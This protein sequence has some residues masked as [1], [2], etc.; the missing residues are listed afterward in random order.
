MWSMEG[1]DTPLTSS[2]ALLWTIE[3][4]PVL[5]SA[6]V[7]IAVLDRRPDLTRLHE[8]FSD[9]VVVFP[10]LA[11]HI[12]A[13]RGGLP[14][15]V[16]MPDWHLDHHITHVQLPEPGSFRQLL[17]L[18]GEQVGEAF[19]P[20]RPLWHFTIVEGL[21]HGRT[22][23]VMK[24]H[25]SVTDGVGGI[26]LLSSFTDAE[27]D[28]Q[29][30]PVSPVAPHRRTKTSRPG[31]VDRAAAA[32]KSVVAHPVTT[33]TNAPKAARSAA[34]LVAPNPH[35][36]SPVTVGRGLDRRLDTLEVALSDL[37]RAGHAVDGTVNDAFLAAV[38]GG[39][40]RYHR[41]HGADPDE[42]RVTMPISVRRPDDAEGGNRF[43]PARFAVPMNIDDP[44]ARMRAVGELARG[45]QH[46]PAVGLTDVMADVLSHLPAGVTTSIFGSML[47][48]MDFVATNIPGPRETRWLAGAEVVGLHGFGPT[49]GSA[50]SFAMLSHVGTCSVGVNVDTTAIADPEVL[51]ECLTEGFDEV[52]DVDRWERSP[53]GAA[54]RGLVPEAAEIPARL[55]ALDDGFLEA[56][57]PRTPMHVGAL[58][59]LEGEA[60]LDGNGDL[61]LD[62]IRAEISR[63][64]PRAPRMYQR[65]A[66][67][68]IGRPF[69]EHDPH[70]DVAAHVRHERL[71]S[72]GTRA[73]LEQL[74]CELQMRVLDRSRPLWEMW[75]IDGLADGSVALVHKIHHA[76]VDGVSAAE[77]F[78]VLLGDDAPDG[79]ASSDVSAGREPGLAKPGPGG[80]RGMVAG[81]TD[82]ARGV[83]KWWIRSG[84]EAAR[85]PVAAVTRAAGIVD[86]LTQAPLAPRSSLNGP[87]GADRRLASQTFSVADL[88]SVGRRHGATVNDVVLTLVGAGLRTLLESRGERIDHV[89]VLVPVSLR[90]ADDHDTAGNKVAAVLLPL[91]LDEPDPV[92]ALRAVAD[93]TSARKSG[94]AVA[95][96]DTLLRWTDTWPTTLLGPVSRFTV[97]RQP[98]VNL[99]VTNVRG[100]D[101]PLFLLGAEITEIT[102]IVPLGGNLTLGVAVLSYNGRLVMGLHADADSCPDLDVMREGIERAYE[103]L[104]H[105]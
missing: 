36:L 78:E 19:D 69:W 37:Q 91:D 71:A 32:A 93:E 89:Q 11:Q 56:E 31:N 5:R 41:L 79:A 65:L 66:E 101:H 3:R 43:T 16:D 82:D 9:A 17:D 72:P 86:L 45:W 74:C 26:G 75:F 58:V 14:R 15:W 87:V 77:T 70:F 80:L 85:D 21:D 30:D 81:L 68:P 44:A 33:I 51:L 90:G 53:P 103:A 104:V 54:E 12:V 38:V 94:A 22:A 55:S 42:L 63:R 62:D 46:A 6:I 64:L 1:T 25:H 67:L 23:I 10:R 83:A 57:T 50:V 29:P 102:P 59:L 18:A 8:K 99:V 34:K 88:K 49:S 4:D 2:E 84:V 98:F 105:E 28:P 76:V 48:G 100:A 24:I 61:R 27:P 20:A 96:V 92:S 7:A 40:R 47:K 73:Q 95:G 39:L 13:S 35:P 60:L 52:I 97:H